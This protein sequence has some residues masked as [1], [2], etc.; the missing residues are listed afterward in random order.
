VRSLGELRAALRDHAARPMTGTRRAA[1]AVIVHEQS[2]EPEVLF[3]ERARRAGDPWSGQMAFPGGRMSKRDP[4]PRAAAERETREEVGVDLSGAEL[5]GQL[6]DLQAGVRVVSPL[7]LSAFVYRVPTPPI[8]TLNHEV[9][10]AL[11]VPA[12]AL[13]DPERHVHHQW[14][15]ARFPGILVGEPDRHVVWGL[16][17]QLLVQLFELVGTRLPPPP[18]LLR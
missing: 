8:L 7:V 16:T 14:G 15:P 5:L 11:W 9:Q 6:H 18:S 12:T 13:I 1:V 10:T 3:I 17:Y 4:D 2:P